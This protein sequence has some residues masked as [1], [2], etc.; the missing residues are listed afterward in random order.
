MVEALLVVFDLWCE[1][2]LCLGG[3]NGINVAGLAGLLKPG[4]RTHCN[5]IAVD[6]I[7][8]IFYLLTLIKRNKSFNHAKY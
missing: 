8:I 3:S 2:G 6:P 5:A 1:E 7:T 4:S